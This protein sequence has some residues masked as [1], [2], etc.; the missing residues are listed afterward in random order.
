MSQLRVEQLRKHFGGVAALN[1][2]SL[3]V[4]AGARLAIIGPNGA[5]KSTLFNLIAGELKPT[6]GHIFF[7]GSDVTALPVHVRAN[8][9]L[10]HTFQRNKLFL[11]LTVLE[12]V[13]LAVQ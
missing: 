3:A 12:N 10:G 1:G 6:A 9:G 11:G 7:N 2:V 4:E 13:R 8:L 5:G